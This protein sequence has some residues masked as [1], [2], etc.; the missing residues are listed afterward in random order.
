MVNQKYENSLCDVKL[1]FFQQSSVMLPLL[2]FIKPSEFPCCQQP[3]V[4]VL[5]VENVWLTKEEHLI[6]LSAGEMQSR[7]GV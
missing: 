7:S 5:C 6:V 1:L 4:C 2:P 3:H